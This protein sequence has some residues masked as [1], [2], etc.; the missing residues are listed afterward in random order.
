MTEILKGRYQTP[1]GDIGFTPSGEVVQQNFFVAQV[2][3]NPDGKAGRFA[4]L[5]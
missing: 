2:R 4:L 3:M 5:P 1:L